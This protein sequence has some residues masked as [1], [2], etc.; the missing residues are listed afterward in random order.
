MT[1]FCSC[2]AESEGKRVY[3]QACL[4]WTNEADTLQDPR[5]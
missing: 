2:V 5:A 4:W 1:R 3:S